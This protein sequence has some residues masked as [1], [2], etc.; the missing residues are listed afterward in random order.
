[1]EF[2]ARLEKLTLH[3]ILRY[4]G[5]PTKGPPETPQYDS[6]VMYG[7]FEGDLFAIKAPYVL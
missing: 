5:D 6:A 7:G 3:D 1:M 4:N 2:Y